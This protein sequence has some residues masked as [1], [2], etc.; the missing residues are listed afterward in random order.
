MEATAMWTIRRGVEADL[1][2]L[3]AIERDAYASLLAAGAGWQGDVRTL[4]PAIVRRCIEAGLLFVAAGNDAIAVG[5]V[6]NEQH[7]E[8]LYI[9]EID[10]ARAAQGKGAGR[11]LM[12][13]VI[14]EARH[15]SCAA[16]YLTTDRLAPFNA[17]FYAAL[18][19]RELAP[20]A[21]PRFL[22]VT[23]ETEI[24]SG[25]DPERRVAMALVL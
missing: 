7:C 22:R 11:A 9:G 25:A 8:G 1:P 12:L 5:F 14:D 16:L 13:R 18:G 19:F 15:R 2:R 24:G 21:I 4:D 6:A 23:L 10:V 3:A 17:P 20:A